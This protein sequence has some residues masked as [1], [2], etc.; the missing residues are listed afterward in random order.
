MKLAV[1]ALSARGTAIRAAHRSTLEPHL[2]PLARDIHEVTAGIVIVQ[3]R[4][5]EGQQPG[6]SLDHAM[7]AA[8][9]LKK[10]RLEVK[11]ALGGSEEALRVLTRAPDWISTYKG[12]PSGD[13]L[14]RAIQALSRALDSVIAR[15]Y[16]KGRPPNW[17]ERRK[18]EREAAGVREVWSK[19]FVS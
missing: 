7:R 17:M 9:A 4:N 5:R 19:R 8:E 3:K 14:I 16:R 10:Q 18:L 1:D 6:N 11:Y 2:A 12:D 13:A 15:S